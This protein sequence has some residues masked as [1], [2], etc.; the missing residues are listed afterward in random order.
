MGFQIRYDARQRVVRTVFFGSVFLVDKMAA[1]RQV[2]ERYGHMQS[3]RII[4]D[5]READILLSVAER[6]Q[7]GSYAAALKGLNHA[8]VGVLHAPDYNANVVINSVARAE[9]MD[10][11]EFISEGALLLWLYGGSA[12]ALSDTSHACGN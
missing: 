8:R 3:L 4:V 12:S 5:V 11:A 1:A 2:A 6:Q 7:F 9:G 10:V